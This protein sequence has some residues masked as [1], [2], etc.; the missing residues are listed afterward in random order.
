MISL[1]SVHVWIANCVQSSECIDPRQEW[2]AQV[3]V[4]GAAGA[5]LLFIPFTPTHRNCARGISVQVQCVGVFALK[6]E[7]GS[8]VAGITPEKMR[9]SEC[10]SVSRV[11]RRVRAVHGAG[12]EAFSRLGCRRGRGESVEAE[13]PRSRRIRRLGGF[14]EQVQRIEQPPPC[15]LAPEP[16]PPPTPWSSSWGQTSG[17]ARK[18]AAGTSGSWD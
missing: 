14:L 2:R 17:S 5:S 6:H 7:N 15:S 13:G 16:P 18:S 3:W 8:G 4:R 9:W 12:T 10:E 11:L 1:F